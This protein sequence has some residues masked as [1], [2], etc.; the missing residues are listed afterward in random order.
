MSNTEFTKYMELKAKHPNLSTLDI[1]A[2]MDDVKPKVESATPKSVSTKKPYTCALCGK[3]YKTDIW[4]H[5]HMITK[6][7]EH[8]DKAK[9]EAELDIRYKAMKQKHQDNKKY[10]TYIVVDTYEK[11]TEVLGIIANWKKTKDYDVNYTTKRLMP[12]GV[13]QY[14]N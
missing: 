6:H 3:V 7:K 11:P 10:R 1:I 2:I 13:E 12:N 5:K 4:F 8:I 9:K 14:I